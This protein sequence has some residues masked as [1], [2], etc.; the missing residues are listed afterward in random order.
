MNSLPSPTPGL[1]TPTRPPWSTTSRS[2]RASPIPYPSC[3]RPRAPS[4]RWNRSKSRGIWSAGMPVP[5][6][7]ADSSTADPA[8]RSDTAMPPSKVY[9]N[10]LET[11][12]RTIFSHMSRSTHPGPDRGGQSTDSSSPA[13]S[14]AEQ[15]LAASSAVSAGRSVGS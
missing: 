6:S 1:A 7:C 12:F 11:R 8:A 13:R 15:K 5:V 4:T 14:Q 9:L 3:V 10:A 2:T